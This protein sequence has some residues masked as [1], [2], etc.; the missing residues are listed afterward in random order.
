MQSAAGEQAEPVSSTRPAETSNEHSI[1]SIAGPG[2]MSLAAGMRHETSRE[3]VQ[4]LK[5]DSRMN[6]LSTV[7]RRLQPERDRT[8][9]QV[10]HARTSDRALQGL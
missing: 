5:L 4:S 2:S 9:K 6:M 1:S 3:D 10:R 7:G 8:Y